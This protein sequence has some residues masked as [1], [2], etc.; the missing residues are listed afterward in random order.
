MMIGMDSLITD[1][2]EKYYPKICACKLEGLGTAAMTASLITSG[3][4]TAYR[5]YEEEDNQ[6]TPL[7][8][9]ETGQLQLTYDLRS[10]FE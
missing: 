1:N 6:F 3:S 8:D 7:I 9:C 10:C 5:C 4:S 2:I